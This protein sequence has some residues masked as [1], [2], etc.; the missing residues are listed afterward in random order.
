MRRVV[1]NRVDPQV[2]VTQLLVNL[3]EM[4]MS[5]LAAWLP[6]NG[7]CA[8]RPAKPATLRSLAF[9]DRTGPSFI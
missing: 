3:P 7:A 1:L 4:R 5:H 8:E 9:C 6:E 2:Y